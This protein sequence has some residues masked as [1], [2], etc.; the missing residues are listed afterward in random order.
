MLMFIGALLGAIFGG[1]S[2]LILG[3]LIGYAVSA[4]VRQLII[5]SLKVA[6]SSLLESTFSI[7][8]ALCKA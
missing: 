6:Q 7:M 5:G 2:G 8:G 3:G 1:F 4:A